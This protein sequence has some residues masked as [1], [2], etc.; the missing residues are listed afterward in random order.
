MF[1]KGIW[2]ILQNVHFMF[3]ID[4]KYISKIFEILVRGPSKF[5]VP[6]FSKIVKVLDFQNPD[7]YKTH[8]F[9]KRFQG[10]S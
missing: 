2:Y 1:S 5:P 7:I 9:L 4:M 8:I 6:T 3:L 10:F